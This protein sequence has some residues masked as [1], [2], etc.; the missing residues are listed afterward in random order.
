E[1]LGSVVAEAAASAGL[2]VVASDILP[3]AP[4]ALEAAVAGV[5]ADVVVVVDVPTVGPGPAE[6]AG[7]V[8]R[9]AA[10]RGRTTVACLLGL[11]GLTPELTAPGPDGAPVT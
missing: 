7:A 6:R 9:A 1:S 8:A 11:S 3:A 5:A 2:E 4:D 10:A